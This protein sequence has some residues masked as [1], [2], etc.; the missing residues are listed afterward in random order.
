MRSQKMLSKQGLAFVREWDA[1]GNL[2]VSVDE[3]GLADKRKF[4]WRGR[5][6]H[7]WVATIASR[8]TGSG[9]AV[10][11]GLQ[12]NIGVNDL[13]TTDPEIAA[14]WDLTKNKSLSPTE[15]TRGSNKK[16][17]WKCENGH[18]FDCT[19]ANRTGLGRGCPYCS[20]RKYVKGVRDFQ[21]LYPEI[22]KEWSKKNSISASE[23][24]G[25]SSKAYF[26]ECQ[27]G[28]EWKTSVSSRTKQGTGCPTCWGRTRIAGEN[29][30]ETLHPELSLKYDS[31]KNPKPLSSYGPGSPAILWWNC[32]EGHSYRSTIKNQA[33]GSKCNVCLN[34]TFVPGVNDLKTLYPEL[35]REFDESRNG[36]TADLAK[37]ATAAHYWWKCDLGHSFRATS[38]GRIS[39]GTGCPYCANVKVWTGFNDFATKYPELL[40]EWHPSLNSNLNPREI[41]ASHKK[42]WWLGDCGHE[43]QASIS[44]RTGQGVGC[45]T[46][47]GKQVLAGFNDL[48]STHPNLISE[49]AVAKN[50]LLKPSEVASG[51][52]KKVWWICE[53]SH[54]WKASIGHRT[55][56]GS[57]RGCPS[58]AKSGFSSAKPGY[59]YLLSREAD[60]LQQF[61]ITNK[62]EARLKTHRK[63]GWQVLDVVGPADGLWVAETETALKAYFRHL[64][65]LLPKDYGDQFDGY[66]ES[67]NSSATKF[68]KLTDLLK[69]LGDWEWNK[70]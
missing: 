54:T 10:C 29:D 1:Q 51:S 41:G 58:C 42:A 44:S 67:W 18:S 21:S 7:L 9:C 64:G 20:G 52:A 31:E 46:C 57:A 56:S 48:A 40:R 45:P 13:V 38:H 14:Q 49:W 25:A 24:S 39:R 12:I 6:G 11:R 63:N 62:P 60:S 30:A 15:V 2:P 47:D 28:H 32:P 34:K 43:W 22:A 19:V 69:V 53:N 3:V 33:L 16:V 61:G 50:G 68:L 66:S 70:K 59:L 27:F 26:W 8:I 65:L 55:Q 5:C 35:A 37:A 36:T 17:W 4:S 23:V